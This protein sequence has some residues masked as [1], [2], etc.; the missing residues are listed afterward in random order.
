MPISRLDT[1]RLGTLSLT[2]VILFATVCFAA[3]VLR[4][5]LDWLRAPLSFYLLGEYGWAG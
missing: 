5:D 3:Q 1:R 4:S 2:A